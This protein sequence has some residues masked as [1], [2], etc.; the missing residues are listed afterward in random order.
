MHETNKTILAKLQY[1]AEKTPEKICLVEGANGK[2]ITYASFWKKILQY[3][4][5]VQSGRRY[6]LKT[7]QSIEY[8]VSF[9]GV[10]AAG[11]IAM[12]IELRTPDE[13]IVELCKKFGAEAL[14]TGYV[15]S[16]E[17]LEFTP[18][19]S[20]KIAC[21]IFTTGTTGK[22]KG[23]MSSFRCRFCGADN[24][25]YSYGITPEDVA[26][27]PQVL[28]HSGGLRRVEA[29]LISGATAV[30]MNAAM[31]FG[32]VFSAIKVYHCNILQFVPAQVTQ[33][34]QRAEKMLLDVASQL[35]ILSVGSAP[36]T[37]HD[38]EKLRTL[39]PGVRLFDDYGSTEAI[40]AAYFEWSAFPPKPGCIGSASLHSKIVFLDDNGA[41]IDNSSAECPGRI[42]TEGGT[43]MSGYLDDPEMTAKVMVDGRVLSEVL[44]YLG[45]DGLIYLV[46]RMDDIIVS[47]GNKISPAE[48]ENVVSYVPNVRECACVPRIDEIMGQLPVLFV[49]LDDEGIT[50]DELL[51]YLSK[52]LDRFK[53]PRI[54]DIH[55]VR[56]LP[57]TAGTGKILKR[58]LTETDTNDE[59]L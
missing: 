39:L 37:E 18:S 44:G 22:S 15:L 43:L 14:P 58:M 12:P 46:G 1:F 50:L 10:Q 42:A 25:R 47:G 54:E 6:I 35:K 32:E 31:W 9:Y 36:I 40:G 2:Q 19:D 52:K 24:V 21:V 33:I 13:V 16:E 7:S 11:S 17:Q 4:A 56:S 34:L 23:V 5:T 27:V 20:E 29:M 38:K 41:V 30:I 45:D 28:S 51:N 48:I 26:L 59:N 55:V 53:I 57:R 49:V 3:A 8:L